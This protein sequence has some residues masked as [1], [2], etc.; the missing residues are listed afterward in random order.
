MTAPKSG[1]VRSGQVGSRL[2]WRGHV[3]KTLYL[4]GLTVVQREAVI[5][6]VTT[7]RDS[8]RMAEDPSYAALLRVHD[9]EVER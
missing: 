7:L 1:R 3:P 2:R 6:W 8:N 4:D 5:D 9:V